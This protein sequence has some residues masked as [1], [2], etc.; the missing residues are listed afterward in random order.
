M[1]VI[2]ALHDGV[3]VLNRH[4]DDDVPAHLAGEDG[5]T[6]RCFGWWPRHR[7]QP[8]SGMPSPGGRTSGKP[9]ARRGFQ[10]DRPA[11][12]A[13][14]DPPRASVTNTVTAS[15]AVRNHPLMRKLLLVADARL[16]SVALR[17]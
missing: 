11:Q 12:H 15:E 6:A 2:P 4:A 9:A 8:P 16:A 13:K 3:V 17:A 14:R 5:E 7:P 10:G 1:T